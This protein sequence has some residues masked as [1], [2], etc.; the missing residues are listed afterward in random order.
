MWRSRPAARSRWP[1]KCCAPPAKQGLAE[2]EAE[3][4]SV[5]YYH[6]VFTLPAAIGAMAFQNKAVVYD[7]LFKAA[8]DPKHPGARIGLTAVLHTW[9]SALTPHR[10]LHIIVPGG[11]LSADGSRRIA[12]KKA[13]FLSVRGL[14]RLFRA[15]SSK[16][17]RR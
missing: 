10:R 15:S 7:R 12:C 16:G 13:F 2:R 4:L 9:G 5:P 8:A 11:G 17:W 14:S 6:V 3:L 1:T